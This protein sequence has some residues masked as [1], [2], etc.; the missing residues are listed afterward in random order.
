[1]AKVVSELV[2]GEFELWFDNGS[3]RTSLSN[4]EELDAI[5]YSQLS[6]QNACIYVNAVAAQ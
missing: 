4:Q 2:T 6:A 3:S 5:S 1:M